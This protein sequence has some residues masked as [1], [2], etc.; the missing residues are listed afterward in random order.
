M[1]GRDF[2]SNPNHCLSAVP[3]KRGIR[4]AASL[5]RNRRLLCQFRWTSSASA[6]MCHDASR[7]RNGDLQR[8]LAQLFQASCRDML[9]SRRRRSMGMRQAQTAVPARTRPQSP[10]VYGRSRAGANGCQRGA[11]FG[12]VAANGTHWKRIGASIPWCSLA[13]NSIAEFRHSA[14]DLNTCSGA[15]DIPNSQG[16]SQSIEFGGAA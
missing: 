14:S 5:P 16:P 8:R 12:K 7:R 13:I 10:L 4:C 2:Y 1:S 15:R 6:R 3:A 9:A 11:P